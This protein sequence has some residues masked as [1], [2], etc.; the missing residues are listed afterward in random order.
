MRMIGHEMPRSEKPAFLQGYAPKQQFVEP[1][2]TDATC[3]VLPS[4]INPFAFPPNHIHI[5]RHPV[6]HEGRFAIVTNVGAGCGGR[7]GGARR[8]ALIRLR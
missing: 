2:Q 7:G 6:P 4:K 8:A 5:S 1:D 3:P